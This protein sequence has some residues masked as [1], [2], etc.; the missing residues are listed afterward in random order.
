MLTAWDKQSPVMCSYI[1]IALFIHI[2]AAHARP[3][4]QAIRVY[5]SQSYTFHAHTLHNANTRLQAKARGQAWKYSPSAPSL[6]PQSFT[7]TT[8]MHA[9]ILLTH[10][11]THTHT[12]I[13]HAYTVW[14]LLLHVRQTEWRQAPS[15]H[16]PLSLAIYS[17][18]IIRGGGG[19]GTCLNLPV[20]SV[21]LIKALANWQP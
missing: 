21:Q 16:P 1:C 8:V 11:H 19:L 6:L 5:H 3:H 9:N 15:I 2:V 4:A 18:L 13:A 20:C 12:I 14:D 7:Q 10:T 17:Y